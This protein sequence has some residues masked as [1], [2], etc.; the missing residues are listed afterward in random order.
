M[1]TNFSHNYT[2]SYSYLS[3]SSNTYPNSYN[4]TYTTSNIIVS[5]SVKLW[6]KIIWGI[7]NFIIL[8]IILISFVYIRW[9]RK[10]YFKEKPMLDIEYTHYETNKQVFQQTRKES[11]TNKSNLN[12]ENSNSNN[13]NLNTNTNNSNPNKNK[14]IMNKL[15]YQEKIKEIKKKSE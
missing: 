3:L 7:T 5:D 11:K 4:N 9:F 15:S 1:V 10:T 12:N 13:K 8:V 2:E 6:D 14:D